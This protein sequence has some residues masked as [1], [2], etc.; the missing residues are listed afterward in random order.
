MRSEQP[1]QR[2]SKK[3]EKQEIRTEVL[4]KPH[5]KV[6][7]R[8]RYAQGPQSE[9]GEHDGGEVGWIDAPGAF[10]EVGGGR[11]GPRVAPIDQQTADN[12]ERSHRKL[13]RTVPSQE[14]KRRKICKRADMKQE[15]R[16]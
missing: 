7:R 10:L 12:E 5:P 14:R 4:P 13:R 11:T 15:D 16:R 1:R 2:G 9:G 3:I 8:R 6:L